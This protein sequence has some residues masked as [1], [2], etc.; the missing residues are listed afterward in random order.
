MNEG[1][2]TRGKGIE[3][4][5]QQLKLELLC[6]LPNF[7]LDFGTQKVE[8]TKKREKNS[9]K[10]K[11]D[12]LKDRIEEEKGK[13]EEWHRREKVEQGG[14]KKKSQKC[15]LVYGDTRRGEEWWF[16]QC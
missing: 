15:R 9:S 8:K 5:S 1:G 11:N 10:I 7:L 12:K 3:S 14:K 13:W 4:K 16:E 2:K 6:V